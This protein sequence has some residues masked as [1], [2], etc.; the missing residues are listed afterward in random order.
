MQAF[1]GIRAGGGAP[2]NVIDG[3]LVRVLFEVGVDAFNQAVCVD[4][5]LEDADLVAEIARKIEADGGVEVIEPFKRQQLALR[6]VAHEEP[7]EVIANTIQADEGVADRNVI[8]DGIRREQGQRT[9]NVEGVGGA[10][11]GFDDLLHGDVIR[12]R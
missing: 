9:I 5:D 11:E 4:G 8:D 7:F 2:M 10:D 6:V 1:P 3:L 12:D